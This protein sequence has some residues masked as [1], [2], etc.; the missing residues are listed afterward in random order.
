MLFLSYDNILFIYFSANQCKILEES[1]QQTADVLL[2][3]DE[4]FDSVNSSSFDIKNGKIY[5]T[6]KRNSIHH[7][8]WADV[9]KKSP[10][11]R[12]SLKAARTKHD[13]TLRAQRWWAFLQ[14]SDFDILYREGKR[15]MGLSQ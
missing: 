15:I 13:L 11:I 8:L 4:I 12:N 1:A 10:I 7:K 3:F 9:I 5:R 14:A 2:F 6:V